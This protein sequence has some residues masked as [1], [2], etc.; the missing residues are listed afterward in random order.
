MNIDKSRGLD[1]VP[2]E[3]PGE[4]SLG[5]F[6]RDREFWSALESFD[7]RQRHAVL[8]TAAVQTAFVEQKI[9]MRIPGFRFASIGFADPETETDTFGVLAYTSP[10]STREEVFTFT[11]AHHEVPIRTRPGYEELHRRPEVH[12]QTGTSCCW[13]RQ[14]GS[15]VLL[16][17]AK[18]VLGGGRIGASVAT[19]HGTGWIVDL[20]PDSIDAALIVPPPAVVHKLGRPLKCLPYVAQWT[21]VQFHGRGSPSPVK[22]KVTEVW[23][24]ASNDPSLPGRIFL[25]GPGQQGDSGALVSDLSGNGVGI[26][27]GGQIN[28]ATERMEGFCQ[29]LG[30]ACHLLH[31]EVFD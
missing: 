31:C 12:P 18:H 7:E 17:T 15:Q 10:V 6:A 21:D 8:W 5:V 25:A 23:F 11:A 14:T 24:R 30:Q 1:L 2:K 9:G 20:A 29:H 28:V 16:L 27:L 19:S 26:Y 13:A 22:T 4:E 3:R